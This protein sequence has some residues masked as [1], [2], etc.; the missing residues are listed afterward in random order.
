[1]A[2]YSIDV[3][4]AYAQLGLAPGALFARVRHVHANAAAYRFV[5]PERLAHIARLVAF[6]EARERFASLDVPFAEIRQAYHKRAMELH[7]DR[8]PGDRASEEA[9]K[10]INAA[11]AAVAVIHA[12]AGDYFRLGAE[13]RA[14]IEAEARR[15]IMRET[16]NGAAFDFAADVHTDDFDFEAGDFA[17][18]S[19][20]ESGEAAPQPQRPHDWSLT[21]MAGSVPRSIR[22]ARLGYLRLNCIIGCWYVTAA[23]GGHYVYDIIMLPAREFM[24]AKAHLAAPDFSY[25][26]ALRLGRF[27]PVYQM[28]DV[29]KIEVPDD[30]A[31]PETYARAFFQEAFNLDDSDR[32]RMKFA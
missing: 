17:S 20:A 16:P 9:L 31:D 27:D 24:R 8:H 25:T 14:N 12:K 15:A 29:K 18:A 5:L 7:P 30:A 21:F 4:Y 11:Y 6:F 13:E 22:T 19:A 2:V 26:P 1:M 10:D 23:N 3:L 32:R 28:L